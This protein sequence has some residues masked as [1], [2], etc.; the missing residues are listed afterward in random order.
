MTGVAPVVSTADIYHQTPTNLTWRIKPQAD[1]VKLT[2]GGKGAWSRQGTDC[3]Q[4]PLHTTILHKRLHFMD[5]A[6]SRTRPKRAGQSWGIGLSEVHDAVQPSA[7]DRAH[8]KLTVSQC[9]ATP[10]PPLFGFSGAPALV[11]HCLPLSVASKVRCAVRHLQHAQ[12]VG[13]PASRMKLRKRRWGSKRKYHQ[14]YVPFIATWKSWFAR[15]SHTI[16]EMQPSL[17]DCLWKFSARSRQ[18]E[19]LKMVNFEEL[20]SRSVRTT[21]RVGFSAHY[22]PQNHKII[23][24]FGEDQN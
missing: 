12:K 23:M 16:D 3:C 14:L 4:L 19:S 6:L 24:T 17:R 7:R 15:A 10:L 18:L 8:L 2:S 5:L 9:A 22:T 20:F 1:Y 13:A 21:R 11:R